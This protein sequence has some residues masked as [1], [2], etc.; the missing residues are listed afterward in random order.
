MKYFLDNDVESLNL[1]FTIDVKENGEYKTILLKENGN[2]ISVTSANKMEYVSL[3]TNY[4]LRESICDQLT[5]FCEGFD[6]I[7]HPNELDLLICGV[8]EIDIQDL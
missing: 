8:P 2:N 5:A 3:Y 7:I 6:F 4:H 1:N